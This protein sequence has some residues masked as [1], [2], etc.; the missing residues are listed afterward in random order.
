MDIPGFGYTFYEH[1]EPNGFPT[2]Q[3]EGI[4]GQ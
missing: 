3:G 4:N 1:C 2:G